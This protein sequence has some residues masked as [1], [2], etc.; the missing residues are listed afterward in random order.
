MQPLKCAVSL[1]ASSEMAVT[2]NE[3]TTNVMRV[4]LETILTPQILSII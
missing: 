2:G 4:E 1:N 3:I